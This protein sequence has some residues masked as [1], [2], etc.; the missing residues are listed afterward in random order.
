MQE[1]FATKVEKLGECAAEIK[2]LEELQGVYT[3]SKWLGLRNAAGQ[4]TVSSPKCNGVEKA[5]GVTAM[6]TLE[7]DSWRSLMR[8]YSQPVTSS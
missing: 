1:D 6:L 3:I 7:A 5:H 2:G 4:V 8:W